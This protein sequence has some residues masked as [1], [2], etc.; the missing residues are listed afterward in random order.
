MQ[1]YWIKKNVNFF[2][3]QKKSIM[4]HKN[5]ENKIPMKY[6]NEITFEF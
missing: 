6:D 5:I 2:F 4:K 3:I 1:I